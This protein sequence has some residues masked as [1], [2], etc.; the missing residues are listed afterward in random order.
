MSYILLDQVTKLFDGGKVGIQNASLQIEKGEFVFL[1]GRSGSGK[2]TLIKLI[3]RIYQPTK[4]TVFVEDENLN[5][6]PAKMVPYLRRKIG[7]VT[8]E[9]GLLEHK[10]VFENIEFAMI[11]TEHSK[12]KRQTSIP[13]ALS[14]VGMSAKASCFPHEISIGERMKVELAR[15]IANNPK[16]LIADEPTASLD[17]DSAWDIMCLLR[18]INQIG[19]TVI[20]ATHAKELVNIMKKRVV[21]LSHGKIIGDV[22]KGK[23]GDTI[24]PL[25]YELKY[26]FHSGKNK[27]L[28]NKLK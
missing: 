12:E 6:M 1:V 20:V 23:Y 9:A 13:A 18:D 28:R 10:T 2:T 24:S 11:A 27:L 22:K 7:I 21:T 26:G 16:I 3:S 19:I 15:A 25:Q 8:Q 14:V 17:P 4:G 5:T